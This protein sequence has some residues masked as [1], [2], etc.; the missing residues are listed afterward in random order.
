MP[1]S[2]RTGRTT[3]MAGRSPKLAERLASFALAYRTARP[4]SAKRAE[5]GYPPQND[6]SASSGGPCFLF[7]TRVG[8]RLSRL[9]LTTSPQ[10][11]HPPV[12]CVR[13]V[14]FRSGPEIIS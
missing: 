14:L 5:P 8:P 7:G 11:I 12:V 6:K 13:T 9:L 1:V 3:K 2:V 4:G 10:P